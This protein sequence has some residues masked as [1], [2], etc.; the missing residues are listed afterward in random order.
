[1]LHAVNGGGQNLARA[2][3]TGALVGAQVG[4]RG[5]PTRFIAGLADSAALRA[6]VQ[7]VAAQTRAA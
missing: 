4:L 1:M 6:I 5:I 7:R 2:M 3:M